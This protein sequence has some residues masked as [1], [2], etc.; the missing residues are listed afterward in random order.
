MEVV[1]ECLLQ[2]KDA[3]QGDASS[4]QASIHGDDPHVCGTVEN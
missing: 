4:Q 2:V 1:H 3:H